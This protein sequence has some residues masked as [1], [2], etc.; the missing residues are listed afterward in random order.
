MKLLETATTRRRSRNHR[1]FFTSRDMAIIKH[2]AAVRN[3]QIKRGE[4]KRGGTELI[5]LCG[6]GR[7]GC[8]IH[9][10]INRG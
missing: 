6:C 2:D 1:R 4:I 8:F 9:M 3:S 10:G 5:V 7:E